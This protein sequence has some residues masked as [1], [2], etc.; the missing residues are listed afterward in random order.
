[1]GGGGRV[2]LEEENNVEEQ[3]VGKLVHVN[4]V[5]YD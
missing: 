1:M 2:D 5:I 4:N 3:K